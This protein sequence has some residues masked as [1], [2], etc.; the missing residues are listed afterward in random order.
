LKIRRLCFFLGLL[1]CFTGQSGF[2]QDY[3]YG[4]FYALPLYYNPAFAG[5]NLN[6]RLTAGYRNQWAGLQG[7]KGW[8]TSFDWYSKK[9][10]SGFGIYFSKDQIDRIGYTHS[11]GMFQY[12]Y[13]GKL[14]KNI[15]ISSGIGI[16]FGQVAWSLGGKVFGDQ[17]E[18]DP[19]RPVSADALAGRSI[20][21][22]YF[23]MQLGLLVYNQNWW[24]SL[25]G[26]H[27]H[28]PRYTIERENTIS[29]RINLSGGYR[30]ELEKPTDYKNQI[31]PR[32][33]TP[34]ILL[35]NQGNASQLDLGV[36]IHYV[37]FVAGIWYRGI[38]TPVK[39]TKKL[40]QDAL[41]LLVGIKQNNLS[42]GYSYDVNLSGLVGVLGGS[43]EI[44]LTYEF[45]TKYLSLRGAKQSRALP[46]PSF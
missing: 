43:H 4:Q 27:P 24:V 9:A 8:L 6:S 41:T 7:W 25:S 18:V 26:L 16:G 42:V 28:S 22:G 15:R 23:D 14:R 12:A 33:I 36:Y 5:A 37:P 40:N 35:R 32:S 19:V 30:F 11:T 20:S 13:R 44:T 45:K 3:Q 29:P 31:I 46:C 38:P 21:A 10:S 1:A 39:G 17:L 2:A 34:A